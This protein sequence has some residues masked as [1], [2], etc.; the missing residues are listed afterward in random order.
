MKKSKQILAFEQLEAEMELITKDEL[1]ELKGGDD[2][3]IPSD[4]VFQAIAFATGR[5]VTE[6]LV[7]YGNHV[8]SSTGTTGIS[9]MIDGFA[10]GV[11]PENAAWLANNFGLT[12]EGDTPTGASGSSF[13]GDQSVAFLNNGSG[14]GHAIVLTGNANYGEYYYHDPQTGTNGTISKT[15]P[16]IMGTYGY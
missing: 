10:N 3:F 8:N 6:V 4:C 13:M 15:D 1:T 5:T 12:N 14:N 9:G 7:A 11:T 2:P 16:R